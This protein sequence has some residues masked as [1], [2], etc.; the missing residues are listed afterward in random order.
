MYADGARDTQGRSKVPRSRMKEVEKSERQN[1]LH[2]SPNIDQ[3]TYVIWI[4]QERVWDCVCNQRWQARHEHGR[5]TSS[6]VD[7]AILDPAHV[8]ESE[9]NGGQWCDTCNL[10]PGVLRLKEEKVKHKRNPRCG[11]QSEVDSKW[12]SHQSQGHGRGCRFRRGLLIHQDETREQ[13]DQSPV[14]GGNNDL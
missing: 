14:N 4:F 7:C 9:K 11:V 5:R 10:V 13:D 2:H 12:Y 8:P 1:R 3:G 6:V